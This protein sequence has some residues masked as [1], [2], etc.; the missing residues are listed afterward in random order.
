M[1]NILIIEDDSTQQQAYKLKLIT[2][3]NLNFVST[4]SE[5][6]GAIESNFPDLII[7]DI[8]LPGGQ[9]GFDVLRV[10]KGSDKTKSVPIIMLTNLG[11]EQRQTAIECGATEF[12][13]KTDIGPE[14]IEDV[15]E[16]YI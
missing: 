5:V 14:Q 4:G 6:Q 7:L 12:F 1:K 8:M 10:L 9:N 13:T 2:K 15:V 3:Y 11:E 16:K